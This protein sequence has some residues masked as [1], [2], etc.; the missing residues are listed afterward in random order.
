MLVRLREAVVR[1]PGLAVSA[2]VVAAL[3]PFA[4]A[5]TAAFAESAARAEIRDQARR[6]LDLTRANLASEIRRHEAVP[7]L[8]ARDQAVA[9]FLASE[10]HRGDVGAMNRRLQALNAVSGADVTYLM[11]TNGL[12]VAASN[13]N[14]ETPF[15]GRN[16]AFR[17]YFSEAMG[18]A[19]GRYFGLG[20]TSNRRGYYF[21][22]PVRD[23]AT[24]SGVVAVKVDVEAIEKRWAESRAEVLVSD[25]DG[26]V[27]MASRP[28][29]VLRSLAPLDDATL[30]RIRESRR[31]DQAP[32]HP[33]P[34]SPP[35][36]P[37]EL[38]IR[39]PDGGEAHYLVVSAAMPESDWTLRVLGD[40]RGVGPGV[41]RAVAGAGLGFA[42]LLLLI[43][44][45]LQRRQR[46]LERLETEAAT[47]LELER[48]VRERTAELER[49]NRRLT[50]EIAE[51]EHA[52]AELR[53]TQAE[54]IQ[55]SKLSAL[56]EMSAGIS[57]ELNQPLAAI[58]AFAENAEEYLAR[59][60]TGDAKANLA[61][62][63]ALTE[64]MARIIAALR[65]FARK[66]SAPPH[67]VALAPVLDD[68]LAMLEARIE[69][70]GVSVN[71][72]GAT[73]GVMV[74]AEPVRL[75]QVLVNVLA[76]ALDAMREV[77]A[78][79]LDVAVQAGEDR[80]A[81]TVRD[82]GPGIAPER[83]SDIFDPFFTTKDV[84]QGLGLGL[85]ISYG[86]VAGF[87]GTIRAGNDPR[88]GAVFTVTL[89]RA[90][91][92]REAARR[93]G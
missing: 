88:G 31:Y 57:H 84:D 77:S 92:H 34:V 82:N 22:A 2:L 76:N 30:A 24:V 58:R 63:S 50:G 7:Q 21:A 17:P 35:G 16:F 36:R 38:V 93:A 32:I 42:F 85:S 72:P 83:I 8:L 6:V 56:G 67:G 13:W 11:D 87:G 66:D 3:L 71:G 80:V 51:R 14:G 48:R 73:P 65:T 61:R 46:V 55:A 62:I 9:R 89:P 23:G 33:L 79:R 27:F 20:S 45:A 25:P 75:Q 91:E 40:L 12:T 43:G 47:R 81:V 90:A 28:P 52:E 53:R 60:R 10:R 29:W 68:A 70:Q 41:R 59:E 15:V 44:F 1:H 39:A 64:R 18:G 19:L 86:I 54:L 78:P 37:D 4:L 69:E 26:V 74:L 5:R 49:S